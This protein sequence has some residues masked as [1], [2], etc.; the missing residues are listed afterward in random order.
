[1]RSPTHTKPLVFLF[2]E[3]GKRLT[4]PAFPGQNLID[5]ARAHKVE[6]EGPCAGLGLPVQSRNS[7]TWTEDLYGEGPKCNHCHVMIPQEFHEKLEPP[8]DGEVELLQVRLHEPE[9]R[10]CLPHSSRWNV[11]VS[12][13]N[14][15]AR[16]QY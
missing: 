8:F 10:G 16:L 14:F 4:V 3:Q 5:V 12:W 6:L 15:R 9:Q 7:A 11:L 13:L 1:M 2:P